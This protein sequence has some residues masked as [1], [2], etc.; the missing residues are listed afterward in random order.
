MFCI[1]FGFRYGD[2]RFLRF[3]GVGWSGLW[4][5]FVVGVGKGGEKVVSLVIRNEDWK[6]FVVGREEKKWIR[7]LIERGK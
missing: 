6:I 4:K 5:F 2:V 3:L 7:F 1:F